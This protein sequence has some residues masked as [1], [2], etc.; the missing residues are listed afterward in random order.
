MRKV[1]YTVT[2]AMLSTLAFAEGDIFTSTGN[3]L[4]AV[5]ISSAAVLAVGLAWFGG[6][7]VYRMTRV[8]V[9]EASV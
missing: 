8:S 5:L 1:F 3:E 2:A 6:R 9:G 4:D 7:A